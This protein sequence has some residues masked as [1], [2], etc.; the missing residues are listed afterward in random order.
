MLTTTALEEMVEHARSQASHGLVSQYLPQLAAA[1]PSAVAIAV[2]LEEGRLVTAGDTGTAFTMQSVVKVFTLLLAIRTHGCEYVFDRV[3]RDQSL[4]EFNSF[5]TFVRTTGIPVNP[6]VNSGALRVVD[7]LVGDGP[8]E[9]VQQ[10]LDFMRDLAKNAAIDVDVEVAKAEYSVADRNRALAYFLRSRGQISSDIE[11]LLW[12]YCQLCA[13]EVTVTDLAAAGHALAMDRVTSAHPRL[14][15][16]SDVRAV[17]RLMLSTG[18]Y[19]GSG[20]YASEVGIPAK[21]GVSGATIGVLPNVCG[22]GIY[23][24]ALDEA[25]NSLAGIGLLKHLSAALDVT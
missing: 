10:V 20:R 9:K 3:G 16:L 8:E 18:M 7:M 23:G 1:D 12:A 5:E 4:G 24:P 13:I 17:R 22:I 14:P 11:D 15:G 19:V 25:A 21:C 2:Q 6:F